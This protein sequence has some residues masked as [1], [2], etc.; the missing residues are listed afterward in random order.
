MTRQRNSLLRWFMVVPLVLLS[1]VLIVSGQDTNETG[2]AD[3]AT[4]APAEQWGGCVDPNNEGQLV[5]IGK[6]TTICL[7]LANGMDWSTELTY[8]R[9]AF[10][11]LADEYSR[12]HIPSCK[13]TMF[14]C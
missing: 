5:T 4:I 12:F 7:T 13:Y 11:P 14:R 3:D 2:T 1:S 6:R 8:L 9:L 10:N